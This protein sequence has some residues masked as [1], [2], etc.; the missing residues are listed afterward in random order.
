MALSAVRIFCG[1]GDPAE[2]AP[3][4]LDHFQA[5]L[6]E[7]RE[8]GTDAILGDDAVVTAVIRLAH[9]GV[10]AHLGGHAGDDEVF[11]SAM[12]KDGMK[13]G[14]VEC[15]L[16]GLVDHGLVGKRVELGNDVVA[17][18]PADE[19]AP[20]RPGI[21]DGGGAAPAD[22]LCRRQIGK[23]GAVAFAGV[24]DLQAG[25]APCGEQGF[26]WL[27]RAAELGDVVPQHFPEA[28]GLQ[29]VALHI[30]DYQCGVG[31]IEVV[32]VR[33]GV[34]AQDSLA[35]IYA[36]NGGLLSFQRATKELRAVC[37]LVTDD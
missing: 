33:F 9:G 17:F 16:T 7:F 6:L 14:G 5:G 13:I 37:G 36:H 35:S 25:G 1:V 3:L 10:D 23:I 8:I 28:A 27:D 22:F 29:K 4:G 26:V 21:T 34:H 31:R 12:L 15:A 11:H 30:D 20:H 19:D 32:G 24:D 2:D 18:L